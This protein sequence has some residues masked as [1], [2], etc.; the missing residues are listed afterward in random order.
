M[1]SLLFVG[2][3]LIRFSQSHVIEATKS[4]N[5]TCLNFGHAH[6][7]RF[8]S[9]FEERFPCGSTYWMLKWGYKYCVRMKNSSV[10]F[11]KIGQEF[12]EQ[13]SLCLTNKLIQQRYYTL[14]NINCEQLRRAGQKIV[15]DCYMT[16]AK[17][18]CNAFHEKNRDCF[19]QL[20]DNEDRSDLTIIRTLSSVGQKCTPKKRLI[21]MRST[22]KKNQCIPLPTL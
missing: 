6:D 8:Y 17:L 11:D 12:L 14:K 4:I 5:K 13:I 22:S 7:C 20:I 1:Y 19:M 16:N 2:L 10:N 3:F 9:C 15:H 21:D 18:F